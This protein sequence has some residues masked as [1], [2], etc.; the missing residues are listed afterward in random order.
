A[1]VRQHARPGDREAEAVEPEL[2][3][4][5]NVFRIAVVE[6]AR[7]LA[8]IAVANVPRCRAKAIPHALTTSVLVAGTLDLIRRGCGTPYEVRGE[9]VHVRPLVTFGGAGA[10][11]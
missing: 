10:V 4:Q 5:R 6:V 11:T 1:A 7:D 9:V 2:L 3:H 8:G